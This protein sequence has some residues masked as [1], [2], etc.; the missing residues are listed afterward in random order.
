MHLHDDAGGR[1]L[2]TIVLGRAQQHDPPPPAG[3]VAGPSQARARR[4]QHL[5]PQAP[6]RRPTHLPATVQAARE[7]RVRRVACALPSV[8]PTMHTGATVARYK[9]AI[10]GEANGPRALLR[11]GGWWHSASLLLSLDAAEGGWWWAAGAGVMKKTP[12]A[13][14]CRGCSRADGGIS[15]RLR[16]QCPPVRTGA[17]SCVRGL[18]APRAARGLPRG[19]HGLEVK[20]RGFHRHTMYVKRTVHGRYTGGILDMCA[21][22]LLLLWDA[23]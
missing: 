1:L 9:L 23:T 19:C 4:Q 6:P 3:V 5:R 14:L 17:S 18:L 12:P 7:V 15:V 10:A 2:C 13:R 8:S 16:P 21:R 22:G 20:S 11:N